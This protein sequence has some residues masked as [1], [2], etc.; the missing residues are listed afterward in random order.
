MIEKNVSRLNAYFLDYPISF[1][2]D[3]KVVH[4]K[5]EIDYYFSSNPTLR[6]MLKWKYHMTFGNGKKWYLNEEG[7]N[8][9]SKQLL[10]FKPTLSAEHLR[11]KVHFY[12]NSISD[13][14]LKEGTKNVLKNLPEFFENP[15]SMKRHHFYKYGLL[16][17]SLQVVEYA[18]SIYKTSDQKEIINRNILIVGG[19][20]HDIGKCHVYDINGEVNRPSDIMLEQDHI[21]HG[22]VLI[23]KYLKAE[24]LSEDYKNHILHIIVSHH[25]LKEWGSPVSPKTL[26]AWM[27]SSCDG[28][29]SK[30]GG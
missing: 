29:S 14:G 20:L 9:I 21:F 3:G 12:I 25:M 2:Y 19:L 26:E 11:R 6:D 18:L 27:I 22:G 10:K 17:H 28:I 8:L 30:I 5:E 13:E 24:S 1:Y 15:A 7:M 23:E 4:V 16:E